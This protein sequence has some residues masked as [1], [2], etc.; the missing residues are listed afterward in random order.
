MN[1]ILV[2]SDINS[3]CNCALNVMIPILTDLGI[4]CC[5]FPTA[6][7]SNPK[8]MSNVSFIDCTLQIADFINSWKVNNIKFDG[9]I[10]GFMLNEEQLE[11]IKNFIRYSKMD[12]VL[13][14]PV[15]GDDLYSPVL[16]KTILI[17]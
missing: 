2:V 9:A 8:N 10:I 6:I 1:K 5:P 13:V 17:G 7:Y 11:T 14:D 4:N 3:T 16:I 15:I 12:N